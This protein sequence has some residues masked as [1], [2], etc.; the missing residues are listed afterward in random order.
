[1][2]VDN[3]TGTGGNL[4]WDLF[5]SQPDEF[6][7]FVTRPIDLWAAGIRISGATVD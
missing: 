5:T 6:R 4:G 1:V 2:V 3:K 7:L